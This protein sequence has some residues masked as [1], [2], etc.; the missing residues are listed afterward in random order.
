MKIV[1]EM[2]QSIQGHSAVLC[3]VTLVGTGIKGRKKVNITGRIK[4]KKLR[5]NSTRMNI[6]GHFRVKYYNGMSKC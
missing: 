2:E 6:L 4:I 1:R 3:K 5:E